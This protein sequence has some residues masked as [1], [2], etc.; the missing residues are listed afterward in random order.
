MRNGAEILLPQGKRPDL[1]VAPPRTLRTTEA[2]P[3]LTSTMYYAGGSLKRE[4]FLRMM[5][6]AQGKFFR[7]IDGG[8][9]DNTLT[10]VEIAAGKINHA[11]LE[12]TKSRVIN[13]DSRAR[14]VLIAAD[15]QIHS[16]T[17]KPDGKTVSRTSG[18]PEERYDS[19]Q[20]FQGMIGAAKATRDKHNYGYLI[21]ASSQSRTLVGTQTINIETNPPNYFHIALEQQAVDFFATINGARL[22]SDELNKFLKSPQYLSNGLRHPGCSTE[23]CGGLDLAVLKKLGAVRKINQTPRES[24]DFDSELESALFAAHVGFDVSVLEQVNPNAQDLIKQ[25]PWAKGIM[26]YAQDRTAA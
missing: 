22:Y 25:W 20:V 19:R 12:L 2:E 6:Q 26:S 24:S 23:I 9:E 7:K 17:L 21:E 14:I 16:P 3:L 11:I 8:P 18:K 4:A 5:A 10:T 1:F 15:V 13:P